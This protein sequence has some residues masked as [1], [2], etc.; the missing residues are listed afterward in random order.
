MTN[1]KSSFKSVLFLALGAILAY[2]LMNGCSSSGINAPE[3]SDL[4]T[5]LIILDKTYSYFV[6]CGEFM[7]IESA[8]PNNELVR[9]VVYIP[10]GVDNPNDEK[11][12]KCSNGV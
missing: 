12:V 11:A 10:A 4:H 9:R 6:P 8:T 1:L 3:R 7:I 2:S 5:H